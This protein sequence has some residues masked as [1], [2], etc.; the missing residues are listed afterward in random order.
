MTQSTSRI[1]TTHVGSLIRPPDLLAL[2]EARQEGKPVDDAVFADALQHAVAEVVRQLDTRREQLLVEAIVAEVSEATASKLGVQFR[3]VDGDVVGR[4]NR[5]LHGGLEVTAVETDSIAARAGFRRGDI[6]V[7]LHQ[8]EMLT[9]ENVMFVL[10]NV[11]LP[12]FNPLKFYIL[13]GGEVKT[14]SV[15]LGE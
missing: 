9:T 4:V 3:A 6:L 15:S 13:R 2:I 12:K 5:Q 7:G 8:W 10:N 11:E 14:G 1:L